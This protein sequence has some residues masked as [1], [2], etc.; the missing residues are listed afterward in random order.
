MLRGGKRVAEVPKLPVAPQASEQFVA[1]DR[2]AAICFRNSRLELGKFFGGEAN[3]LF[4][5]SCDYQHVRA[6]R[7]GRVVQ[8]DLACDNSTC[9]NSHKVILHR[10]TDRLH[11]WR[12]QDTQ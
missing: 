4:M 7:N 12:R 1:G 9:G 11:G 6:I 2:F 3:R 8:D 5:L 10:S